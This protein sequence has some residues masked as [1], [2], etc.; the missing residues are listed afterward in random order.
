M[1]Y[2]EKYDKKIT[3]KNKSEQMLKNEFQHIEN[4]T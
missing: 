4:S 1:Y 2:F 3:E